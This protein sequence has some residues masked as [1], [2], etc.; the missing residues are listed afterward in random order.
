MASEKKNWQELEAARDLFR[1]SLSKDAGGRISTPAKD[2]TKREEKAPEVVSQYMRTKQRLQERLLDHLSR[3]DVLG[4]GDDII[5]SAVESFVES[6]L[7]AEELPL[8]EDERGKLSEELLEEAL[9]MGPLAILMSDPAVTDILVNRFDQVYVERF[10]RMELSNVRFR[11]NEHVQRIIERLAMRCG[12]RIDQSWP[13]A[14]LRLPDGSRVNATIAPISID[15]PTLSIRRFGRRRINRAD[16]VRLGAL[17]QDMSDFLD[18]AVMAKRNILISGG[19]GVGK[20]TMLGA[21]AEAIPNHDRVLTIEDTAELI[22]DQTHV[23][24]LET[25]PAN[26]EGTGAITA[27]DLVVNSLRMRPDRII[28]GEVRAGE[29]LDMLQ[30]MNTGHEGGLC[31]VHANTPRDALSR[32]ETMTLMAGAELPSRAIREQ[33]ASAIH[34]VVQLRRTEDG[35]RRIVCIT[36]LTGMEDNTPLLQDIFTFERRGRDGKKIVGDYVPTGIVPRFVEEMRDRGHE[37]SPDIF[38]KKSART[39]FR[40]SGGSVTGS[41][42]AG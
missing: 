41:G 15:G 30:A 22:L 9:G 1:K 26:V 5:A 2:T 11:D 13:M 34:L 36:E 35:A 10:G 3:N 17:S 20:S 18:I 42:D 38:K 24:R 4:E 21:I 12:R 6:V 16:L 32:L 33:I 8:N 39:G 29:A 31:T 23:V 14:D 19:T 7:E 25:R 28:L 40:S 37:L 27:R